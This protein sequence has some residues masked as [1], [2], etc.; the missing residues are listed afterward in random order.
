MRAVER[1]LGRVRGSHGPELVVAN[2]GC[3]LD[4]AIGEV[5]IAA[6]IGLFG[7]SGFVGSK[8]LL[9]GVSKFVV[10]DFVLGQQSLRCFVE[11]FAGKLLGQINQGGCVGKGFVEG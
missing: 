9:Q 6:G 7:S 11:L 2:G 10:G 5:D 4:G 1:E 8:V 3:R